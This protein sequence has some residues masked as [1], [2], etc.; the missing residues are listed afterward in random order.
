MRNFRY[1]VVVARIGAVLMVQAVA[2]QH[3]EP[4]YWRERL[5]T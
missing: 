5:T 3:R 1:T 4:G 2:H